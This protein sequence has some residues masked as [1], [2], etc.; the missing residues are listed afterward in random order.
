MASIIAINELTKNFNSHIAV[1]HLNFEVEEGEVFGLLVIVL[2]D[3]LQWIVGMYFIIQGI[4]YSPNIL[5][6]EKDS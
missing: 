5:K 3:L 1:N 4:F 6:R 2:P